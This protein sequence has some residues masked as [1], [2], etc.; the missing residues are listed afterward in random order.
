M[1]WG[2]KD[3]KKFTE[4]KGL[5]TEDRKG[6]DVWEKAGTGG[7]IFQLRQGRVED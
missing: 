7:N 3:G 4:E 1:T 6:R 2:K 5:I